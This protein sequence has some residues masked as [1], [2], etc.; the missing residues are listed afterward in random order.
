VDIGLTLLRYAELQRLIPSTVLAV[1]AL[2]T[3]FVLS[4]LH[5]MLVEILANLKSV[6]ITGSNAMASVLVKMEQFNKPV[7]IEGL[8]KKHLSRKLVLLYPVVKAFVSVIDAHPPLQL[9][10]HVIKEYHQRIFETWGLTT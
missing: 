1:L 6:E 10:I 4:T 2:F 9:R 3:G 7:D 8:L 5:H